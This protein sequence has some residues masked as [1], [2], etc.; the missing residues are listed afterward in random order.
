MKNTF[1][2][3]PVVN[4][5]EYGFLLDDQSISAN[6]LMLNIPKLMPKIGRGKPKSSPVSINKGILINDPVCK[7]SVSTVKQ[8]QNYL[9]V[10]VFENVDYEPKG[11]DAKIMHPGEKFIV[12][13]P[14]SNVL[15]Y[16]ATGNI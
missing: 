2:D 4:E 13:F 12:R 10:P 15:E 6:P 11:D 8:Q 7:P 16:H 14:D 9:A 3:N 1:V 5:H